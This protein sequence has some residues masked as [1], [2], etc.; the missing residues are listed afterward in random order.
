MVF[1]N[2]NQSQFT[3]SEYVLFRQFLERSCGI[4]LGDNKN[5]LI[6][7]RLRKILKENNIGSLGELMRE[8]DRAGASRLRQQVIDAMTTNETLWFRDRHPFEYLQSTVLPDLARN[9]GDI[10]IWCAA[11]STGQ[12][13]YSI[14]ICVEELRRRN[15]AFSNKNV[16]ILATDI[17]SKVLDVA[18]RGLYEPLALKRGMSDERLDLHFK[19]DNEGAWEI[20]P[21]IKRRIEF[22]PINLKDSFINIGKFHVVFCRNVLIYFSSELQRQIITNIHRVLHPGGILFLGGSETPKGLN[23][24]FEIR[25]YTPGVVYVKK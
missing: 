17:S 15:Y 25:Y 8:I 11:C 4:L 18:K 12:E 9:P 14:S 1:S 3:E 2:L 23:D 7:S 19:H 5:Y 24:L 16:R 6:D 13:P 10:N 21:E 22:R 20:N